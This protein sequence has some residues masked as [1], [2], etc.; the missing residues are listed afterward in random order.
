MESLK[1]Q[2][3]STQVEA[4]LSPFDH[5]VPRKPPPTEKE[6]KKKKQKEM[7]LEKKKPISKKKAQSDPEK[8]PRYQK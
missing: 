7:K 5:V 8:D 1:A 3:G 2:V 6:I 4:K